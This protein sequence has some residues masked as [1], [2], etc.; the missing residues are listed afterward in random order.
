MSLRG[1]SI[2]FSLLRWFCAKL[3][4]EKTAGRLQSAQIYLKKA[5]IEAETQRT[6]A[7]AEAYQMRVILEADNTLALKL[8]AEI[9]IQE[10]WA[11]AFMQMRTLDA[12]K[13]L[14]YERNMSEGKS[15]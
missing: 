1:Q 15:R 14:N 9:R 10:L 3:P 8:G 5:R 11:K 12:A 2:Q 6:L 7:D 13:R 4:R